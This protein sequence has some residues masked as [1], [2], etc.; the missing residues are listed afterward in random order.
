MIFVSVYEVIFLLWLK[1]YNPIDTNELLTY[2][3][4]DVII[5]R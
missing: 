4:K 5:N 3:N 1:N 2:N